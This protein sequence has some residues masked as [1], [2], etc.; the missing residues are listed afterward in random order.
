[1]FLNSVLASLALFLT[2]NGIPI[3][4]DNTSDCLAQPG[5]GTWVYVPLS[6]VPAAVPNYG[7]NAP[8]ITPSTPIVPVVTP[9]GGGDVPVVPV[10][11]PSGGGG[12]HGSLPIP[13]TPNYGPSTPPA[14]IVVPGVPGTVP[15]P[16]GGGIPDTL[17]IPEVP[18]TVPAPIGGGGP[19][20]LPP[21]YYPP[22]NFS[23]KAPLPPKIAP[24]PLEPS[25][26][27]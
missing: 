3:P 8:S 21:T 15:T 18:G 9:S 25:G 22:G 20:Y 27:C 17:P 7:P 10:V 16:I 1:M 13:S 4:G 23:P 12:V 24:F 11:T 26:V 2:V 6:E 19:V 5:G 14:P